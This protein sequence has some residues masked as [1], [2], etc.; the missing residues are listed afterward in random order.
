MT[1]CLR[2]RISRRPNFSYKEAF[3]YIDK[4]KDGGI[5]ARDLKDMLSEHCFYAT[6][7]EIVSILCKFDRDADS[8][9]TFNEFIEEITP[10]LAH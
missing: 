2:V 10:K 9:I 4:D 3:D 1:E 6:E 8:R 7:R 5:D